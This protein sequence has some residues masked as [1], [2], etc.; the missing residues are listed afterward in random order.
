MIRSEEERFDAVLTGGLPR[1]EEAL[2]RGAAG[3]R[4]V[5]GRRGVPAVRHLRPAARLHRGHGRG[6][7]AHARS[8]GLRAGDGR[9]AREGAREEQVRHDS[10]RR[11]AGGR[12]RPD[13]RGNTG[14]SVPR[15]RATSLNTRIV[16][17]FDAGAS[18]GRSSPGRRAR[19]S[20]RSPKRRSTS[21]LAARSRTSARISGPAR[22][23]AA[24]T[25]V[26]EGPAVR[27]ALAR[28]DGRRRARCNYGDPVPAEV[29]AATRDATRRNHTATHLLHAALR[30]VL[31]H[32]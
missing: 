18:T 2:D 21:R 3:G 16:A 22:R 29:D 11:R 8:R 23:S 14:R 10:R 7:Q 1:L 24:V 25:D 15:L 12:R 20:L 28:G 13:A 32:T 17:L 30:Q 4:I 31:G 9:P 6:P 26:V 5:A 19:A 27:A